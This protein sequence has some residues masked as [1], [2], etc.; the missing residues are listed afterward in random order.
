MRQ[1]DG[2]RD[3]H[4]NPSLRWAPIIRVIAIKYINDVS[5]MSYRADAD[6]RNLFTEHPACFPCPL[7]TD[8]SSV[9]DIRKRRRKIVVERTERRQ[10]VERY[11]I[12]L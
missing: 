3:S 7:L 9:E 4:E 12:Y 1:R 2:E 6:S 5:I 11:P 10:R 8:A